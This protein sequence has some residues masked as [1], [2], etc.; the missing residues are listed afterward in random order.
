[1]NAPEVEKA[2]EDLLGTRLDRFRPALIRPSTKWLDEDYLVI[3]IQSAQHR[4]RHTPT[5]AAL[6][7]HYADQLTELV[8]GEV[9]PLSSSAR[10]ELHPAASSYYPTHLIVA[11]AAAPLASDNTPTT[12]A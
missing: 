6:L 1:M 2:A 7:E 9:T 8:R 10:V 11:A 12:S 4:D 3:D 5:A